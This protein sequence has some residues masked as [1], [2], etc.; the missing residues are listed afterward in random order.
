[1]GQR[2]G[3]Q[4]GVAETLLE[5]HVG[6]H[7]LVAMGADLVADLPDNLADMDQEQALLIRT[8]TAW[9]AGGQKLD[10][11]VGDEPT[12]QAAGGPATTGVFGST[13]LGRRRPSWGGRAEQS[14]RRT[15]MLSVHVS[16]C[17]PT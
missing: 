2:A 13:L 5:R 6:D 3:P 4:A 12:P 17:T 7:A 11:P 15:R 8:D 14:A 1:M 10:R 16:A 9:D